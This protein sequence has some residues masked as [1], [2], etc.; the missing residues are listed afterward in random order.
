MLHYGDVEDGRTA[1]Y[2]SHH[3]HSS[4]EKCLVERHISLSVLVDQLHS[5]RVVTRKGKEVQGVI[6]GDD[7][8]VNLIAVWGRETG[9]GEGIGCGLGGHF[10]DE[11]HEITYGD[12]GIAGIC[13][14]VVGVVSWW[15]MAHILI[16]WDEHMWDFR[17][18]EDPIFVYVQLQD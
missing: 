10:S 7:V 14:V 16:H 6:V 18:L 9:A 13:V 12:E 1:P 3:R 15:L 11:G 2:H 17:A 4:T 5:W 8:A